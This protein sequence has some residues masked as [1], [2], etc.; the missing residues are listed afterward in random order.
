MEESEYHI[1]A[2]QWAAWYSG[3]EN[4]KKQ[5]CEFRENHIRSIVFYKRYSIHEDIGRSTFKSWNPD[6]LIRQ[7]HKIQFKKEYI[8]HPNFSGWSKTMDYHQPFLFIFWFQFRFQIWNQFWIPAFPD[9]Y[10]EQN[11]QSI[12]FFQK[13]SWCQKN[14]TEFSMNFSSGI[15]NC[16]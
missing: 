10:W 6:S 2:N 9:A 7:I 5:S 11:R 15:I 12:L 1:A 14:E 16:K 4:C 8:T 3:Q 13:Y